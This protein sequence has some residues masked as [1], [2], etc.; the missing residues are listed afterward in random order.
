MVYLAARCAV[1][2][3]QQ[4]DLVRACG[5]TASTSYAIASGFPPPTFQ[6]ILILIIGVRYY[7]K[8]VVCGPNDVNSQS[9]RLNKDNLTRQNSPA[10]VA[11]ESRHKVP[12]RTSTTMATDTT[13]QPPRRS[14]R[15]CVKRAAEVSSEES[16]FGRIIYALG[17]LP[18]ADWDDWRKLLQDFHRDEDVQRMVDQCLRAAHNHREWATDEACGHSMCYWLKPL[19]TKSTIFSY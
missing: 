13:V 5:T 6:C 18:A 12:R 4:P 8:R 19:I 10:C 1:K 7:D 14:S 2:S 9:S 17:N 15:S 16:Q 11:A 3:I